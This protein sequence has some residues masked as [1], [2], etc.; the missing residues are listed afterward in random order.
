MNRFKIASR[1]FTEQA[2][3]FPSWALN[4]ADDVMMRWN[5]FIL[6]RTG[7]SEAGTHVQQTQA[8]LRETEVGGNRG[9]LNRALN[10]SSYQ[11]SFSAILS[12]FQAHL[13][14]VHTWQI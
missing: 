9:L 5:A 7:S 1:I 14:C 3:F 10:A 8:R 6:K 13:G 11:V 2:F 4:R 12:S